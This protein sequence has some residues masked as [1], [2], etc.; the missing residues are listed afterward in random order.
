[1]PPLISW[2]P[3]IA[4][5]RPEID[6]QHQ[7]LI[8]IINNL[9]DGMATGKGKDVLG[10]SLA[11]LED[12]TRYHFGTEEALMEKHAYNGAFFHKQKHKEFVGQLAAIMADYKNGRL[13]V[14]MET[15]NFLR[16]WLTDHILGMDKKLSQFLSAQ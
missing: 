15:M 3:Q 16:T 5:G 12:Y 8:G 10:K 1:M 14:S 9:H 13:T 4:V 11:E 7:K 2:G 6:A